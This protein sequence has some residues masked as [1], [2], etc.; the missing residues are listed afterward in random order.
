MLK[1]RGLDPK[2]AEFFSKAARFS[3][4]DRR[5]G[6]QVNGSQRGSVLARFDNDGQLCFTRELLDQ[7]NLMVPADRFR[8]DSDAKASEGDC[9]DFMAAFPQTEVELRP[10]REEV[11]L[12]G[13]RRPRHL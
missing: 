5:V 3:A 7:A 12:T 2:V 8:I 4:G 1:N 11:S 6:L 13:E 9:Y 10:S